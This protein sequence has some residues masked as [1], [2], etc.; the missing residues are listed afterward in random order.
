MPFY[1]LFAKP[2]EELRIFLY[3]ASDVNWY[4]YFGGLAGNMY[5]VKLCTLNI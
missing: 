3:I 1:G 4:N 2:A 5:K